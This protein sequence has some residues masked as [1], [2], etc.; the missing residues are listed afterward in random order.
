MCYLLM[1]FTMHHK[2]I[3]QSFSSINYVGEN[4]RHTSGTEF[5]PKKN[6]AEGNFERE[7]VGLESVRLESCP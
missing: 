5:A 4:F 2:N 1:S 7:K 3:L 6:P